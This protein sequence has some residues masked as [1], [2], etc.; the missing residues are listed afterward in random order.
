MAEHMNTPLPHWE[1]SGNVMWVSCRSC[2]EWF[3]CAAELV[4]QNKIELVCPHC[5]ACFKPAD[6]ADTMN[7]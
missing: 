2:R 1:K 6:A 4:S 5:A 7:P 3:P